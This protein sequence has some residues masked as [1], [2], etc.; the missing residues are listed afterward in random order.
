MEDKKFIKHP[1]FKIATIIIFTGL[2]ALA[3]FVIMIPVG[4]TGFFNFCD[5]IV[6]FTGF[7]F[8]P[9]TGFIAGGVGP[10]IVDLSSGTY[11]IYA[12]A[13]VIAHGLQGL[14]AGLVM[15]IYRKRVDPPLPAYIIAGVAGIAVMVGTYFTAEIIFYDVPVAAGQVP[16]NLLQSSV[17]VAISIPLVKLIQLA[18]PP[19]KQYRF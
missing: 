14:L 4:T 11:A 19:V 16:F 3:T 13:T 15:V 10:A 8:G 7:M 17:G 5:T 12:P 6:Y 1:A 2:A 9:I 18:Y